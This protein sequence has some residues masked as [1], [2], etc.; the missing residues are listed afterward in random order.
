MPTMASPSSSGEATADIDKDDASEISNLVETP[1]LAK[2]KR[3]RRSC[4][5][6]PNTPSIKSFYWF[7]LTAVVTL[8]LHRII[9]FAVSSSQMVSFGNT[10]RG[11]APELP[12]AENVLIE[13]EHGGRPLPLPPSQGCT[14]N[15]TQ[16]AIAM[17]WPRH[18]NMTDIIGGP[19]LVTDDAR[20]Q[21][22][23][24]AVCEYRA[25]AFWYHPP[26]AM[27][28]LFGCLS[29]WRENSSKQPVLIVPPES[30]STQVHPYIVAFVE[31][32]QKTFH[33]TIDL[34]NNE[35]DH[36]VHL[37]S[38][39]GYRAH[40]L[41][42]MSN[43]RDSALAHYDLNDNHTAGCR[44]TTG[45]RQGRNGHYLPVVGILNRR[46]DRKLS[47][48]EAL[49]FAIQQSLPGVQIKYNTFEGTSFLH[50][51]KFMSE[52]DIV[53]SPHGAQLMSIPYMPAC[54]AV[55]EI[56]P[57]GYSIPAFYGTLAAISS[58]S[59]YHLYTGVDLEKEK[60]MANLHTLQGRQKARGANVCVNIEKTV[61]AVRA[62]VDQWNECCLTVV[63]GAR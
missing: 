37:L 55:L 46:K 9:T 23:A 34:T 58:L 25:V 62:M 29:W 11:F 50:Q 57:I 3:D 12:V 43:L 31:L 24:K 59:H 35:T 16:A 32:L 47:N 10:N 17:D 18:Y 33:V 53:I 28:Q 8:S 48:H 26:H 52:V 42:V 39:T 22:Y 20:L 13:Q 61:E 49:T 21:D 14:P 51:V 45:T 27:Q 2:K 30:T 5:L 56:S 63:S 44:D 7:A 1:K 36:A 6:L 40:S 19:G 54:G 4:L 41:S 38:F 15:G 60:T